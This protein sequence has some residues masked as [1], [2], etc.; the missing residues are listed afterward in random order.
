MSFLTFDDSRDFPYYNHNPRFSKS[1]WFVLILSVILS[2]VISMIVSIFSE[3]IGSIIFCFGIL[4]PLLYYSDWDYSLFIRKPTRDEIIL[5]ILMFVGYFI[6]A[7]AVGFALDSFGMSGTSESFPVDFMTIFSL[8]FSMMG[9]EL[10]KFV[11]LM[12]FM[13]F[14]YKYTGNRTLSVAVSSVLVL[15]GFAFMHYAP[16]DNTII[17]VLLFQGL[18]SMFEMYGYLKTKNII[19]PYISHLLTDAVFFCLILLGIG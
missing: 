13:R 17:S 12:F 8:I 1:A 3:L 19:V 6:Y 11:P 14:V 2:F 16:P 15:I 7:S 9:E 5:G 18:G 4:I 10:L